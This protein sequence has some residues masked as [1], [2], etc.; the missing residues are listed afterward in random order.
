MLNYVFGDK[1]D[2]ISI[3]K[4]FFNLFILV[5]LPPIIFESGYNLKRSTFFKNFGSILM[6]AFLGTGIAMIV[7]TLFMYLITLTGMSTPLT[8]K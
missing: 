4:D 2:V 7:T 6:Y 3:E 5:L 1:I 8:L